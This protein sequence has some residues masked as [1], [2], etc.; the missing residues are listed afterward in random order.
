MS[1]TE[2]DV[3]IVIVS[4]QVRD[5]LEQ[6]LRSMER[7][8]WCSPDAGRERGVEVLVIDNHSS[9]GTVEMVRTAF[10][11]VILLANDAN[12]GFAAACNQARPFVRGRYVFFLNPDT[13]V[14]SCDLSALVRFMD[15][16]PYVA[17]VGPQLRHPDGAIQPSCRRFPTV[18]STVGVLLKLQHLWPRQAVFRRYLMAAFAHTTLRRVDQIM[19]AAMLIRRAALDRVGWFD[20]GFFLWFD[21]VDLCRRLS[22][23]GGIIFFFPWTNV[24][25]HRGQSFAQQNTLWRQWHFAQSARRYFWKHHTTAAALFISLLSY[26]SLLPAL[27]LEV[28]LRLRRPIPRAIHLF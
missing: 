4:W 24:I 7:A 10:P 22:D 25:H 2:I 15:D 20:E 13:D 12:R 14:S 16:Q 21:E 3:S 8:G 17:A 27:V 11:D 9:D 1:G 5:F 26:L 28:L 6:L 23:S 19:G 18:W